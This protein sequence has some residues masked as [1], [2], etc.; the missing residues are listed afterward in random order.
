MTGFSEKPI[1]IDGAEHLLGRLAAIV[2]KQLLQGQKV[3]V[4]RTEMI[5]LSGIFFRQK[6]KYLAFLRKRC[7]VQPK[8]G[9]FHYRAPSMIF[10]RTVRGML[11]H[12]LERGKA[13]LKRL[14]A[15]EGIP[16]Q[17]AKV[18][19]FYVPNAMRVVRLKRGRKYSYLGRLSHEVGWKYQDVIKTLEA[20]RKV[21]GALHYR[22][23]VTEKKILRAAK[24]KA[25]P[26]YA[27]HQRVIRTYGYH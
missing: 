12:K 24:K 13:A 21:K 23:K 4:V 25:G 17:Y 14:K 9:P 26:T 20:K 7:N 16:P 11:P 10:W 15:Y 6:L 3:V 2:A 5:N 18:K 27:A 22:T 19:K 1:V 8:R